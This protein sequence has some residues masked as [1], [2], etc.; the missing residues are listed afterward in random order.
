M[1]IGVP[2]EIKPHEYRVGLTPGSVREYVAAGH[3]VIVEAGAGAG[4]GADDEAYRKAGAV[5]ADTAEEIFASAGM[6]VKVKEPQPSE[7]SELREG[8]I[9]FTYLHLAPDPEQTRGLLAS[10]C[11]AIAYETVTDARGGLPLLAPMSE[12]AG[13]LA[14]EAAG[15]ALQR[16]AGGRGVLL[17]GVPG[18]PPARVAV[19]GGGVVGTHAARMAAGLGAEVTILDRSLPR[20]RE[21]DELFS[22]R[23]RTRFSTI[24]AVESEVF[25]AD[26][27]IGAVLI[28]GASAPKLVTRQ[29]LGSMRRGAVVVD[30]AIDQGGC[31][32]TSKATTHANPTYEVDG[33]VHYCV[34]NM[35]GAVP[36]TSSYA[37]N[38][39]T[40][41]FG[42]ALAEKG[43]R[44]LAENAHLRAGL[45][46]HSGQVTNKAVADSLGLTFVPPEQA[47]AA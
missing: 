15:A 16:H 22:G 43:L 5:I 36:L 26:V 18:V 41:P 7:W 11:T 24:D 37:L 4:I 39:A 2:K 27:V 12:V 38:N 21:L 31:F 13:R 40:L 17:G 10:R 23:V 44:A 9:L 42:L 1:R 19:I 32:E 20:L 46:I 47:V 45:N 14:I 25:A 8:Q 3:K 6:I 29:M 30:V 28:P 33:I 34:A 35:P